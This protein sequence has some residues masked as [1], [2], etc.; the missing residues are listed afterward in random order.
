[1]PRQPNRM[2]PGTERLG[3]SNWVV[4][5]DLRPGIPIWKVARN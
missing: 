4:G 1:M 5:D 3:W 2:T